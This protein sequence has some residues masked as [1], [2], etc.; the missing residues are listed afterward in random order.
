MA[1]KS[2]RLQQDIIYK[3]YLLLPVTF[4]NRLFGAPAHVQLF[5]FVFIG[6]KCQF[7]RPHKFMGYAFYLLLYLFN[8]YAY[9]ALFAYHYRGIIERVAKRD[10]VR[11]VYQ[12]R[13][14]M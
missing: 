12:V 8:I 13:L 6:N 5:N 2:K 1:L 3:R 14:A 9:R 4:I 7:F 10:M 11:N